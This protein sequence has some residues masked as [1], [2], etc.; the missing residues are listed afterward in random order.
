MLRFDGYVT[1]VIASITSPVLSTCRFY[2]DLRNDIPADLMM[3]KYVGLI[4]VAKLLSCDKKFPALE[5][6]V[7]KISYSYTPPQQEVVTALLSEQ[8]KLL[9]QKRGIEVEY[10]FCDWT[11]VYSL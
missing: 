6:V 1:M 8:F 9:T 4:G 10:D 3:D 7:V 5:R 2:L 11:P